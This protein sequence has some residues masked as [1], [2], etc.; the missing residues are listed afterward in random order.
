MLIDIAIT[1]KIFGLPS[2]ILEGHCCHHTFLK[3]IA[4][5][6]HF[7]RALLP[8]YIFEGHCCHH[9]FL[10]S[11]AAFIHFWR[12]LLPSYIFEGHCWHNTFLKGIAAIINFWKALLPSYLFWRALLPS[13]IFEGHCCH[14]IIVMLKNFHS[15]NWCSLARFKYWKI[16]PTPKLESFQKLSILTR[17]MQNISVLPLQNTFFLHT[18]H[19]CKQERG[20][21]KEMNAKYFRIFFP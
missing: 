19:I 12:V 6:I 16:H 4:D 21:T 18:E 13:Y 11:I 8:S 3:S 7:W 10:K 17:M 9:T 20:R 5:L 14:Q 15:A 2:Y 1:E